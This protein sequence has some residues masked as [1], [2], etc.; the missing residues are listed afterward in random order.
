MCFNVILVRVR[1]NVVI[2]LV[3]IYFLFVIFIFKLVDF[4]EG[5][6]FNC[7]KIELLMI[8]IFV[9]VLIKSFN[10][11]WFCLLISLVRNI[12]DLFLEMWDD[13]G[14]GFNF[15][16]FVVDDCFWFL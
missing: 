12:F 1:V 6:G 10:L 15:D 2:F 7:L 14:L 4:N 5:S 16:F 8:D 3:F 11:Y 13:F 9:F